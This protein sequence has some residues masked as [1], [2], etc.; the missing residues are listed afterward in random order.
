MENEASHYSHAADAQKL[1]RLRIEASRL[2]IRPFVWADCVS[3]TTWG[4]HDDPLYEIY[5]RPSRLTP[6][7]RQ[8]FE[9]ARTSETMRFAVDAKEGELLGYI[10]LFH[11]RAHARRADLGINFRPD[12]LGL[13]YGTEALSVFLPA[14]FACGFEELRLEVVA[15]NERA[16]RCYKKCGFVKTGEAWDAESERCRL[17]IF[18][19]DRFAEARPWFRVR[20]GALETLKLKM[21]A[22]RLTLRPSAGQLPPDNGD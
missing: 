16:L 17:D 18:G 19:D 14:Y 13:G 21:S 22:R 4:R 20:H 15:F 6:W 9:Q 10:S 7:Y 5:N 1:R 12:R 2:S 3:L 11:V 8:F